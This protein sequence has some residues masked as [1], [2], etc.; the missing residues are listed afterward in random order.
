M[1]STQ[2]GGERGRRHF[3]RFFSPSFVFVF[4][5]LLLF[6]LLGLRR[7]EIRQWLEYA[8]VGPLLDGWFTSYPTLFFHLLK[9]PREK[10]TIIFPVVVDSF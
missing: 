9:L 7:A 8:A 4:L 2:D 10:K 6:F 5:L 3:S 1:S